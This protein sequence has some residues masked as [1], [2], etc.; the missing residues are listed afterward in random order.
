MEVI[1]ESGRF[2]MRIEH[3]SS[4][5]HVIAALGLELSK[6]GKPPEIHFGWSDEAP[7][8]ANLNFLLFGE[9]NVP[10]MVRELILKAEPNPER[11]PRIVIG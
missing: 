3:A 6:V 9:G 8:V 7:L 10:W 1:E 4:I 11:Q 2:I 5:A